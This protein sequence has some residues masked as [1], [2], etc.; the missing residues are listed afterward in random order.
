MFVF[1]F[2]VSEP[3]C[4]VVVNVVGVPRARFQYLSVTG[5][6]VNI[7]HVYVYALK[8]YTFSFCPP[9]PMHYFISLKASNSLERI[10]LSRALS[11]IIILYQV[12]IWTGPI[13]RGQT[14]V[15]APILGQWIWYTLYSVHICLLDVGHKP[16]WRYFRIENT[17]KGRNIDKY[18][19]WHIKMIMIKHWDNCHIFYMDIIVIG[20]RL[21]MV[22]AWLGGTIPMGLEP[23]WSIFRDDFIDFTH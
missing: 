18:R 11:V 13:I 8:I 9:G 6:C 3:L 23:S 20:H 12:I 14:N 21:L 22:C 16:H 7:M 1:H 19:H 2:S 10:S 17:D 4:L 15:C 5:Y